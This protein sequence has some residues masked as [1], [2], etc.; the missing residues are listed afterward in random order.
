MGSGRWPTRV[1]PDWES[2]RFF[3]IRALQEGFDPVEKAYVESAP[4]FKLAKMVLAHPVSLEDLFYMSYNDYV[5]NILYY[6]L[7]AGS[8]VGWSSVMEVLKAAR[9]IGLSKDAPL[10]AAHALPGWRMAAELL[11][12]YP[13]TKMRLYLHMAR[14]QSEL[15]VR[16]GYGERK[17]KAVAEAIASKPLKWHEFQAIKYPRAFRD[18]L[19][20]AHP[21]PP[22]SEV[23][24]IW[25]YVVNRN[26]PPTPRLEVYD[27][28]IKGRLR[29]PEAV[30]AAIANDLPWEVLR[31]RVGGLDELDDSLIAEAARRIMSGHDLAMQALTIARVL[32][33]ARA[34]SII[35]ARAT[36]G[37]V[38]PAYAAARAALGLYVKGFKRTAWLMA[39]LASRSTERL[40]GLLKSAGL[41]WD[42][43]YYLV[44]VSG[45]MAGSPI[46][47]AARI[48]LAMDPR[49]AYIFND[50]INVS[51]IRLASLDDYIRL[52]R[53]PGCGTPLYDSILYMLTEVLEPGNMLVVITDE[54]ENVST[55]SMTNLV[56][57]IERKGVWVAVIQ[58]APYPVD[59]IAKQPIARAVGLPGS[60]PEAVI[61]AATLLA[62]TREAGGQSI[63]VADERVLEIAKKV[64]SASSTLETS[65]YS[66]QAW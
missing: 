35:E 11:A 47:A 45:S 60:S 66:L 30:E 54:Q 3:L 21:K 22:N 46:K 57:T 8:S 9:R 25:G 63:G 26:P 7:Y 4:L 49:E 27:M 34:T 62:L 64:L 23:A 31:S 37:T 19:R 15:K 24:R 55:T 43:I 65:A 40:W 33:D 51:R 28:I 18:T 44:D 20:M 13:V 53:E 5:V 50:C 52:L 38:I 61:A 17:R 2:M 56:N 48:L 1:E 59:M 32:G 12:E 29:G 36:Q 6:T 39:R 16:L 58:V 14:K 10:I 42:R 41:S